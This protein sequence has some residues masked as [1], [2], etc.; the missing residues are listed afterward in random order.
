SCRLVKARARA[1]PPAT[2]TRSKSAAVT[3]SREACS[4]RGPRSR[5]FSTVS[6]TRP[7]AAGPGLV[8]WTPATGSF[9]AVSTLACTFPSGPPPPAARPG[10]G[11]LAARD[12]VLQGGQPVALPVPL[13]PPAAAVPQEDAPPRGRHAR[14]RRALAQTRPLGALDRRRERDSARNPI[15]EVG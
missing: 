2:A 7:P 9:R 5:A 6:A 8:T 3:A 11:P 10:V 15:R 4:S 14:Q 1:A 12:R 13:R